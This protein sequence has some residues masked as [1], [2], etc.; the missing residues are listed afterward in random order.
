MA[1]SEK[2][3]PR[4]RL[5]HFAAADRRFRHLNV[6]RGHFCVC[7]QFSV[8]QHIRYY[9]RFRSTHRRAFFKRGD[10]RRGKKKVDGLFWCH[11]VYQPRD[12]SHLLLFT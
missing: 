3:H 7:W 2:S 9:D 10:R 5:C 11:H 12:S 4:Q 6:H 1:Q 8:T